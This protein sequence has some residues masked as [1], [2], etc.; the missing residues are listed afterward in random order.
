VKRV[1][2][3]AARNREPILRVLERVFPDAGLVL[4]VASGSGEHIVYFADALPHLAWQ[5]SDPDPEARDSIA[6]WRAEA[7]SSNILPPLVLDASSDT[8]PIDSADAVLCINM[9][10]IAPFMAC[11]GLM[12]GAAR[13]LPRGA[14]LVTY[15]PYTVNGAHTA[16]SNAAFDEALRTSNPEWGVR[17][18]DQV[19]SAA[20]EHGIRLVE[21]IAMPANNFTLVWRAAEKRG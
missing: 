17:D 4:E 5:P 11:V 12:R 13:I 19:A 21:R 3:A 18:I 14:A 10:H 7:G 20:A 2:P 1:A 6:A 16:P 8:W 15:G 9:I